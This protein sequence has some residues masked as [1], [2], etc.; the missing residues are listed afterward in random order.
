LL[1]DSCIDGYN[2]NI[3]PN[4]FNILF[5]H[6]LPH[7]NGHQRFEDYSKQCERTEIFPNIRKRF[8]FFEGSQALIVCPFD[9][10][11]MMMKTSTEQWWKEWKLDKKGTIIS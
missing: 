7:L 8:L 9:K 1:S 5:M 6:F 2:K 11:S 4:Q 3:L 10:K